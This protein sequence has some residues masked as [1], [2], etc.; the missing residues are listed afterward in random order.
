MTLDVLYT[1]VRLYCENCNCP[2]VGVSEELPYVPQWGLG[3]CHYRWRPQS[4]S[5]PGVGLVTLR[6]LSLQDPQTDSSVSIAPTVPLDQQVSNGEQLCFRD[7]DT[8]RRDAVYAEVSR[9]Q[10]SHY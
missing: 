9:I 6:H 1:M 7:F 8:K 10:F 3:F 5:T 2:V 4:R